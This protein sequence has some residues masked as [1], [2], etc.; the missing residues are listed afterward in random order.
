MPSAWDWFGGHPVA[1]SS[2][3]VT[4]LLSRLSE[5]D[6][7]AIL[8]LIPLVY[9][10]LRQLASYYMR[11]ERANHT[12]RTTGL[13]HEAYLR[14]V[15]Q[16]QVDWKGRAHF[17]GI[18]AQLMRRILVDHARGHLRKK[19]GGEQQRLPLSETVVISQSRSAEVVAVDEALERLAKLDPRQN[20]IVELRFFGGLTTEET[21]DVLG[22]SVRTVE[23]EWALAKAWLFTELQEG[24]G[25]Q[26]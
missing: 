7:S 16:R 3:D 25:H 24:H 21:A 6:Q 4:F 15:E 9:D 22:V 26:R 20:Q 8:R 18:A 12:L 2:D 23:R 10:E 1:S 17:F 19:R 5:G 13:V 14:L 11:R